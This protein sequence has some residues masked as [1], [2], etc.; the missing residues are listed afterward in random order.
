[1]MNSPLLIRETPIWR[2]RLVP[3]RRPASLS[4][5]DSPVS[6]KSREAHAHAANSLIVPENGKVQDLLAERV[7]FELAGDFLA[8]R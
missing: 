8:D 3:A 6:L 1:M 4:S 7:G 5:A 2:E